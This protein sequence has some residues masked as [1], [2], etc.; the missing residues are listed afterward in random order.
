MSGM[1][2]Q[3]VIDLIDTWNDYDIERA[4]VFYAT[5]HEAIDV[6]YS[7]PLLGQQGGSLLLR[8]YLKAFPDLFIQRDKV[9][10]QGYEVA[11][12]WTFH[13][14]HQGAFLNIPPTER[15]VAVRGTSLFEIADNQVIRSQHIW[16][17]AGLLR[18]IG[19]LPEL[20]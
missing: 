15:R 20:P 17:V 4:A 7:K 12:F 18:S 11:L 2:A 16:D 13:G 3:L 10:E 14:T 9:I 6:A 1:V 8:H 19:L 5:D